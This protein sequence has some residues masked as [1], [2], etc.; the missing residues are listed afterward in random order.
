MRGQ[1][2][3]GSKRF[4]L[5]DFP[6]P[7]WRAS[8]QCCYCCQGERLDQVCRSSG[9]QHVIDLLNK[10][11]LASTTPL[12]DIQCCTSTRKAAPSILTFA[13][14]HCYLVPHAGKMSSDREILKR[15]IASVAKKNPKLNMT[16]LAKL[17]GTSLSTVS[18]TLGR[19]KRGVPLS[20]APRSGRPAKLQGKLL[21]KALKLGTGM[22][23]SSSYV[24]ARLREYGCTVSSK[25]VRATFRR[26]GLK[27]GKPKRGLLLTDKHKL[28]KIKS[29][30]VW[31]R[32]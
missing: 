8:C 19:V 30:S 24:A 5:H 15:C 9:S 6:A 23:G 27:F 20:D 31:Y 12:Q 18:R 7:Q 32:E 13:I 1:L 11:Q 21:A 4:R 25:T 17:L 2:L 29:P 28:A 26:K 14:T 3:S 22:H 16:E 10:F